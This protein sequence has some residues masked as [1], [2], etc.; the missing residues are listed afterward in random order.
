MSDSVLQGRRALVTAPLAE[1]PRTTWDDIIAVNLS[2]AF[3]T[4]SSPGRSSW[5]RA[6]PKGSAIC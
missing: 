5:A 1:M 6:A 4:R 2:A 3:D